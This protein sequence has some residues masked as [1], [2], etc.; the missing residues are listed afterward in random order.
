MGTIPNIIIQMCGRFYKILWLD[1][2][3]W[4]FIKDMQAEQ[5]LF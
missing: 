4:M 5:I 2:S 3:S 1:E